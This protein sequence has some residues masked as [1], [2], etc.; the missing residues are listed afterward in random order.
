MTSVLKQENLPKRKIFPSFPLPV[1]KIEEG[2][3]VKKVDPMKSLDNISEFLKELKPNQTSATGPKPVPKIENPPEKV[4]NI[5][6]NQTSAIGPKPVP[7]IEKLSD[8]ENLSEK[9]KKNIKPVSKSMSSTESIGSKKGLEDQDQ[10][11]DQ[12]QKDDEIGKEEGETED[13]EIGKEEG[14]TEDEDDETGKEEGETA[15]EDEDEDEEEEGISESLEVPDETIDSSVKEEQ[16]FELRK[17]IASLEKQPVTK[18]VSSCDAIIKMNAEC[19][20]CVAPIPSLIKKTLS[21][22]AKTLEKFTDQQLN[23]IGIHKNMPEVI[24]SPKSRKIQMIIAD[25]NKKT[26]DYSLPL[27]LFNDG[28]LM[29]V[30]ANEKIPIQRIPDGF[31]TRRI[32]V[33]LILYQRK[34]SDL[35]QNMILT[36][37]DLR[38]IVY[39]IEGCG[40]T[41]YSF[42][43]PRLG[44]EEIIDTGIFPTCDADFLSRWQ[45]YETL[46]ILPHEFIQALSFQIPSNQIGN[47]SPTESYMIA[48]LLDL[49]E[50]PFELIYAKDRNWSRERIKKQY[51]ILVPPTWLV[52]NYIALNGQD[53]PKYTEYEEFLFEKLVC[54]PTD[55]CRRTYLERYSDV[56]IFSEIKTYVPYNSRKELIDN[57]LTLMN[58]KNGEMYFYSLLPGFEELILFGNYKESQQLTQQ[59]LIDK[60][61]FISVQNYSLEDRLSVLNQTRLLQ[62][63]LLNAPVISTTL[64]T[65]A[66]A[67]ALARAITNLEGKLDSNL[68]TYLEAFLILEPQE[69]ANVRKILYQK[70][71]YARTRNSLFVSEKIQNF[72]DMIPKLTNINVPNPDTLQ[73]REAQQLHQDNLYQS[74]SLFKLFFGKILQ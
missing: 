47:M 54:I 71:Y 46:R 15:D 18:V 25:P 28:E 64:M 62:T 35:I 63:L 17:L 19:P 14:E 53:Y 36:D 13:D 37:D 1:K 69:I 31:N 6:P 61:D 8:T 66:L 56:Q 21:E 5:K 27:D 65:P 26:L 38:T 40:D 2:L 58:E 20:A 9:V 33:S 43:L 74:I 44:L 16:P 34:R 32:L 4:K 51:G 12:D 45:R 42:I 68:R 73:N 29:Y 24:I 3:D 59:D 67:I 50:N 49:S 11:Q 10:D 52:L 41:P 48:R 60:L 39:V 72:Y 55:D 57:I 70:Y 30:A 22:E 7:K 23:I